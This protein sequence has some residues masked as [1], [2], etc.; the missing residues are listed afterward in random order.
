MNEIQLTKLQE[1]ILLVLAAN[2]NEPMSEDFLNA[3][4]L[5]SSKCFPELAEVMPEELYIFGEKFLVDGKV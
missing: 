3:V 5:F 4:L 2:D 1:Y